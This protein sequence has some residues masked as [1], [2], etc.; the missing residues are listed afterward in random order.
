MLYSVI[1]VIFFAFMDF[2]VFFNLLFHNY[3]LICS[4]RMVY[5]FET[6]TTEFGETFL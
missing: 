2:V 5:V 3:L 6:G 4:W 1:I